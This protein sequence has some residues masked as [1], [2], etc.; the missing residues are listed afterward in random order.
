[1]KGE[2][3]KDAALRRLEDPDVLRQL[4]RADVISAE[5]VDK[6]FDVDCDKPE[7]EKFALCLY[8]S[9]MLFVLEKIT[10]DNSFNFD[11][12]MVREEI[13]AVNKR[14]KQLI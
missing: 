1:M 11:S 8:Q 5:D 3:I 7:D 12:K 4:M 13:Y 2:G 6:L 14:L 10:L 9:I